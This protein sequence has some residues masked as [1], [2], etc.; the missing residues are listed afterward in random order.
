MVA[1]VLA[2][3]GE[4]LDDGQAHLLQ[5]G[6]R[7]DAGEHQDLGRGDGAA[8][9]YDLVGVHSESLAAALDLDT[10]G[11]LTVEQDAVDEDVGADGEIEAV[12]V[13]GDVG[14]GGAHAYAVGVVHGQGADASG[15]GVVV[16]VDLAVAS[17]GG[18]DVERLLE[19]QPRPRACGAGPGRGRR[20]RGSRRRCRCRSLACGSRAGI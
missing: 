7:A 9:E 13:V 4:V 14:E 18:G 3:A 5:V 1:E 20:S 6:G 2:D 17:R 12:A 19:G 10:A 11:A 16:V 15:V 8:A